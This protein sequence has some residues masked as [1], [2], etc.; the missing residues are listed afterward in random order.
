MNLVIYTSIENVKNNIKTE[1]TFLHNFVELIIFT[2]N[3][4]TLN[5][6]IKLT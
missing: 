4:N 2:V 3:L 6:Y 1:C 5:S